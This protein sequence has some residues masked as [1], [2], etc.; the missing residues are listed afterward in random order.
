V[1]ASETSRRPTARFD[2]AG[3]HDGTLVRGTFTAD[4]AALQGGYVESMWDLTAAAPDAFAIAMRVKVDPAA[5]DYDR[6]FASFWYELDNTYRG[7]IYLD[8]NTRDGLRCQPDIGGTFAYVE[9]F[10]TVSFGAWHEIACM[11]D[12]AQLAIFVD[13]QSVAA[14]AASGTFQNTALLPVAIGASLDETSN[15]QNESSMSVADVRVYKRAL[16]P[17]ELAALNP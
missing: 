10:G 7:A 14:M 17:A 11:Y 1:L 2:I 4:G 3:R 13:G 9:S 5:S 12:G 8:N 16:T 15:S 6:Y